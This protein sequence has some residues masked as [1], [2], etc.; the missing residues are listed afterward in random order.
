MKLGRLFD[1]DRR[2]VLDPL[3]DME[4]PH[5]EGLLHLHFGPSASYLKLLDKIIP[6]KIFHGKG[7]YRTQTGYYYTELGP[8]GKKY[9]VI[10]VALYKKAYFNT[11]HVV[12]KL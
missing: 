2:A 5:P 6:I 1:I 8:Y 10:P 7:Q 9:C 11:G 12:G 4:A 3:M